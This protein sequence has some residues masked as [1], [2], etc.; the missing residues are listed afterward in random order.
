M[1]AESDVVSTMMTVKSVVVDMP[2]E[3]PWANV[4]SFE[5]S[6]FGRVRL[7]DLTWR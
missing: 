1:R 6:V 5:T 4:G 7:G 2:L 3:S